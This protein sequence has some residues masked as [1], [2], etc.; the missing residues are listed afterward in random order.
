MSYSRMKKKLAIIRGPNLNS[1]EM[2]NYIPLMDQFDIVGF[3]SYG[4]NFDVSSIPF[5]VRKLISI[6]QLLKA[7]FLRKP[8]SHLIGDYHDLQGL[9]NALKGFDVVHSVETS[10][11]CSYQAAKAK[12]RHGFK[13]VLTV[14]ENIPFL[15]HLPA[16]KKNKLFIAKHADLFLPVSNRAKEVLILEGM[17]EEKII[18]QMPGIDTE[19]FRPMEKDKEFLK[20][21]GCEE[22]DFIILFVANLYRE[23]GIFDLI[24][25]FRQLL[26]RMKKKDK[27]K[28]LIGGRGYEEKNI[29]KKIAELNLIDNAKLIGSFPYSVMPKIHNLADVFVLPS[30]PIPTWQ[31]QFGYVLIESMACGKPVISTYSGSIPEVVGDA[32]ILVQPNDFS[33]IAN[34]IELLITEKNEREKFCRSGRNRAEKL[35]NAKIVSIKFR[36]Y[37][38]RI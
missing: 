34:A 27:I 28:L 18:V 14:W 38:E 30:L 22:D 10:Y 25:A 16:T 32:G 4:H 20:K 19:H 15:F 29:R 2:Q 7:R 35:F 5:E 36:R 8:M 24:Y 12:Q 3:T 31:E 13:L 9:E 33:S 26:N 17:P 23:K 21:F 1:W 6:G 11:Y 37:F